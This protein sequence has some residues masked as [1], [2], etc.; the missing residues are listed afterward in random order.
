MHYQRD[1]VCSMANG[2]GY[3]VSQGRLGLYQEQF[4]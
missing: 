3:T 1:A 4:G 2:A